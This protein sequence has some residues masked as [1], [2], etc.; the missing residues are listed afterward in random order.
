ML[1]RVT[2]LLAAIAPNQFPIPH[3]VLVISLVIVV[4]VS[5]F[6]ADVFAE[7]TALMLFIGLAAAPP[8]SATPVGLMCPTRPVEILYIF[9][10]YLA[11][12]TI[13]E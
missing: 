8:D 3:A 2:Q 10:F 4:V 7:L 9:E 11:I 6:L 1:Y 13:L 12:D 5:F